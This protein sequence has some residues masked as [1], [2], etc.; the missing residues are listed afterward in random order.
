MTLPPLHPAL[1]HLPIAFVI[2]SVF[3]DFLARISKAEP[4][5]AIL[6]TLGFWSL[7]AGLAGGALTIVAGYIDMG[8]LTLSDQTTALVRLHLIF[9][10]SLAVAL[11]ILTAWRWLIW[12]RGQMTINTAYLIGGSLVLA[13]TLFQGWFGGEMVYSYGAGVVPTGQGT[14]TVEAAQSRLM[15]VREVL[16]PGTAVGGAESPGGTNSAGHRGNPGE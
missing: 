11:G 13:L 4:R 10:W 7:V 8:R 16:Q 6:R 5:R 2:L 9:G 14:E 12:H 3:A 15:A 1:V